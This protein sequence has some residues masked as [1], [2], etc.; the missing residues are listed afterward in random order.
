MTQSF[1]P[2]LVGTDVADLFADHAFHCESGPSVYLQQPIIRSLEQMVPCHFIQ[3]YFSDELFT[4]SR[5][6]DEGR[7]TLS[8]NLP[9]KLAKSVKLL[10]PI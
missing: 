2:V 5:N 9:K 6:A 3:A 4:C 7:P 10:Q 1:D 8:A